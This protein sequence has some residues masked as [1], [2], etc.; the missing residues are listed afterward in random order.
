MSGIID[1]DSVNNTI[2]I[3]DWASTGY[4]VVKF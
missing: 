1:I 2:N 3:K 4:G